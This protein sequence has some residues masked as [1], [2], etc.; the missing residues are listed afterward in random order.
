MHDTNLCNVVFDE[1]KEEHLTEVMEIY[2]YYILYTNATFHAHVLSREE[3]RQLVFFRDS[4]YKAFIIKHDD[5]ICG[6][7]I[8][9][10]HKNREAYDG[11]AEVTIYLRP[12]YTGKGIGSKAVKFIEN[13]AKQ[14]KLHVLIATICGENK[15]SINLFESNGFIKCAHYKEV[16]SKFGKLLDVVAYQKII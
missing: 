6:Y 2:T 1:I 16:G 9:A 8:L 11:T 13:I 14:Q 3:M 12:D 5:A 15:K 7:V 10:Q 4:R